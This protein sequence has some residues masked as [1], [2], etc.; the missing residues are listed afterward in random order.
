MRPAPSPG[1]SRRGVS[2]DGT[3]HVTPSAGYRYLRFEGADFSAS[4]AGVN[5]DGVDVDDVTSPRS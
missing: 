2:Y 3:G 1:T 4:V 5:T